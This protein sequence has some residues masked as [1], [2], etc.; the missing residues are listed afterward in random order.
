MIPSWQC[1]QHAR[2]AV[3]LCIRLSRLP[4]SLHSLG[5]SI[6]NSFQSE[7][8]SWSDKASVMRFDTAAADAG[9]DRP[10]GM[11]LKFDW[12]LDGATGGARPKEDA[13]SLA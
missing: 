2:R 8:P 4:H 13:L 10:F 1:F 3:G 12:E 9:C 6:E 5:C 11:I 7:S